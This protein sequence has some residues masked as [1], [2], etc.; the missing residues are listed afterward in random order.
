LTGLVLLL[1]FLVLAAPLGS[2]LAANPP[3]TSHFL[4]DGSPDI[5]DNMAA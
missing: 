2:V 4:F 3:G 5:R 1:A